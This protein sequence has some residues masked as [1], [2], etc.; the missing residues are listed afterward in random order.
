MTILPEPAYFTSQEYK[1]FLREYPHAE[2]ILASSYRTEEGENIPLAKKEGDNIFVYVGLL[3]EEQKRVLGDAALR[4]LHK[5][6]TKAEKKWAPILS[7][8]GII[9]IIVVLGI[10]WKMGIIV[11]PDGPPP[12]AF[13]TPTPPLSA[14]PTIALTVPP[15]AT[16]SPTPTS[17]PSPTATATPIT[18]VHIEKVVLQDDRHAFILAVDDL[19]VLKP[20]DRVILDVQLNVSSRDNIKLEYNAAFGTIEAN[21]VYIA[22]VKSGGRDLITVKAI[23]RET[24]KLLAQRSI[25]IKI[26]STQ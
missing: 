15:T 12:T 1:R 20:G 16:P 23:S 13:I 18:K 5:R 9:S 25:K 7:V 24:G 21:A 26:I 17:T 14:T 4:E 10:L 11:P 22:P 6:F 19:Y 3:S 8:V 2:V